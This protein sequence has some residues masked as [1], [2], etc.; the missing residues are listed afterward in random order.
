ME[1]A[2]FLL[3]NG[4]YI[5]LLQLVILTRG[6]CDSLLNSLSISLPQSGTLHVVIGS[7]LQAQDQ[8]KFSPL[9]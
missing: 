6:I 2:S 5:R 9:W 8:R 7:S 1:Y 3:T 4:P